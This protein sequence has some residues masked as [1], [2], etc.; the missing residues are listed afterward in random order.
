[1]AIVQ[2]LLL[3]WEN[4]EKQVFCAKSCVAVAA[5]LRSASPSHFPLS[6]IQ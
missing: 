4:R 3:I 1:M 6:M 2:E 5:S